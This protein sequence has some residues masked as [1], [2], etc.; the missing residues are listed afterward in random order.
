MKFRTPLHLPM[1]S[2]LRHTL[3]VWGVALWCLFPAGADAHE[4]EEIDAGYAHISATA[5]ADGVVAVELHI[6]DTD[7]CAKFS[8]TEIIAERDTQAVYGD[9]EQIEPCLFGG[10][11]ELPE[12]GRWAV[13]TW[14]AYNGNPTSI[15]LP[16]GFS[17]EPGTFERADWL[18][19]EPSIASDST[20]NAWY[21]PSG[22]L[23][24][25]AIG[26][27]LGTAIELARRRWMAG[28]RR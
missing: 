6:V 18:H 13:T 20:D 2:W 22:V 21:R 9:L 26:L 5:S 25:A 10:S 11:I 4:G 17:G 14:V 15:E 19:V 1:A 8:A 16:V 24:F 27:L 3:A 23:A 12:R 28:G 7:D